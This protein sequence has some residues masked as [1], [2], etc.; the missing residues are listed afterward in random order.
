M[1]QDTRAWGSGKRPRD[2]GGAARAQHSTS[3][4]G[5]QGKRTE[6]SPQLVWA[7]RSKIQ[8]HSQARC[9]VSKEVLGGRA[10]PPSPSGAGGGAAGTVV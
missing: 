2:Q 3:R 4:Q 7:E 10:S 5:V 6:G 8:F 1:V 9:E